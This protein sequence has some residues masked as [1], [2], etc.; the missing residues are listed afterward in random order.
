MAEKLNRTEQLNSKCICDLRIGVQIFTDFMCTY[1][2]EVPGASR[3]LCKSERRMHVVNVGIYTIESS[4]KPN[5]QHAG[6]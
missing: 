4:L 3:L 5:L 1:V 2:P 6:N